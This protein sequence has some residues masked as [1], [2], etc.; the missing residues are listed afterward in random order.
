MEKLVYL[1]SQEAD[2]AGAELRAGLIEKAVPALRAAGASKI[3]VNVDDEDVAQGS[4]V[5]IRRSDPPFRAMVSFWM[6]SADDREPCEAALAAHAARLAGYLVAESRPMVHAP[7]VGERAPG[8]NLVTCIAKKPGIS[9]DEFFER[10][11]VEH[12]KVALETQSTFAYVR[13]AVVRRLTA[14]GSDWDGIVEE[15]FPI[16]ALTDPHVWYDCSSED[17]Y[18]ARLARMIE[19]VTAFLDLSVLESTPMSEYLLD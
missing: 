2:L 15:S 11:N 14:D 5:L 6:E 10:W 8:A 18:K 12:R 9:D 16:E 19:S 1:L 17:E 13:N 3:S 4:G 7:P